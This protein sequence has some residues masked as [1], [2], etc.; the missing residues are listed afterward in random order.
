M[1]ILNYIKHQMLDHVRFCYHRLTNER[2][3]ANFT[4]FKRAQNKKPS[5]VIK[6]ELNQLRL[7]WG[8]IPTQYYT[9]DFYSLDC[10]LTLDDM[11]KYIPSY[12]F[13]KLIF[14]QY[15]N[16]KNV[17]KFIE[18]KIAM[19]ALFR[20]VGL[21]SSAVILIKNN[22]RLTNFK[23]EFL[24]SKDVDEILSLLSCNKLFIKPVMGRGGKGIIIAKRSGIDFYDNGQIV[25]YNY[26]IDLK[27]DYIIESEIEQHYYLNSIYSNSVNTLR[28]IT[29]RHDDGRVEFIAAI[30][31]MGVAGNEIDNC[32][33]GGLLIG[34]DTNTGKCLNPFATFSFGN[35][36]VEYHPDSGFDFSA[37]QLPNWDYV[38]QEILSSA[39]KITQLNLAGWD[40]AITQDGISIIEVNTLFGIDGLQAGIGGIRDLFIG[41]EPRFL[42]NIYDFKGK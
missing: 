19:N 4:R 40:I 18:N 34:I 30:L 9:Y 26:L 24:Q 27:G 2:V 16:V 42:S 41:G 25:N 5:A 14:P 38:K 12:Y 10:G 37:L 29:V 28:A 11:K 31:R 15:D 36:R 21:K 8:Y 39:K 33:A 32:C 3:K 20:E 22:S 7:Y 1:D 6:N 17:M 35:Q 23:N 13:Y